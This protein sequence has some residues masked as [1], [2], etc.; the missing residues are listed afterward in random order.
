MPVVYASTAFSQITITG[1]IRDNQ[2]SLPLV[3]VLLLNL[4]STLVKGTVTD[5]TG[6]FTIEN[7][8]PGVYLLSASMVGYSSFFSQ[9]IHTVSTNID[10]NE[11]ILD[12]TSTQLGELTVNAQKPLFDQQIDRI[13]VNVS[14]SILST[15]NSVLEVLQKSPGVVVNRQTNS[16][17]LNGKSPVRVMINNKLL[18]LPLKLYF[19]CLKA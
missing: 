15:G 18:Q 11:I 6:N 9:Q 4:D 19:R 10:L 7:V 17:S 5:Q 3:T 14:N 16:I 8:M 12:E 13:V 1:S 2:Q